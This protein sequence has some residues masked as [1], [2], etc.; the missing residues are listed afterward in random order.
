METDYV[1]NILNDLTS[2]NQKGKSGT[3]IARAR[4]FSYDSLSRLISA[5]NPESGTVGY[6][7]D[8]NSNLATK[9]DARPISTIYGYDALNRLIS[10]SYSS[11]TSRTPMSCFQYDTSSATLPPGVTHPNWVGRLTNEWTAVVG[12]SCIAP[13]GSYYTLRSLLSYDA[14]GRVTNE[15]QCTPD[16]CSPSS[17]PAITYSY[18]MA[19]NPTS[20]I[21]S[22]GAVNGSG[23]TTPLTLTSAFDGAGHMNSMT[24]S[25][26]AYPTS[27]Y[28][29]SNY[30]PVG[31]LNWSLGPLTPS[32]ILTVTQGYTNRLWVNS[33]SAIGQV[34]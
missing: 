4:G 27:I 25:W 11:D 13:S 17:G 7:Y 26:S 18:D 15:Q 14:M 29:L 30:G 16:Q 2:V 3:D 6:S 8:A 28:T 21:N 23:Q 34:P 31:P 32:P 22:V 5:T 20:L 1:Y 24:S 10:K 33:I 19:G 12:S 9:T